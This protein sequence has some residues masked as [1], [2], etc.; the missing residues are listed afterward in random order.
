MTWQNIQG[1]LQT[2]GGNLVALWTSYWSDFNDAVKTWGQPIIN[3]ISK[4]FNSIWRG[5]AIDP[6]IRKVVTGVWAGDFRNFA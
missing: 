2:I 3:S 5:T 6:F 4:L 1:D